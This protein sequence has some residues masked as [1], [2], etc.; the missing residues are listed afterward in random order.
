ME[1]PKTLDRYNTTDK[2][3]RAAVESQMSLTDW[4]I[5]LRYLLNDKFNNRLKEESNNET[6]D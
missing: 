4:R 2:G 3:K 1:R 6:I 5:E